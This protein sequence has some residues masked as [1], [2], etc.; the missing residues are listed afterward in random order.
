MDALPE[1][2]LVRAATLEEVI[3]ARARHPDSRLLGGGTDLVVNIRRGIIE[4]PEWE[5]IAE[6]DASVREEAPT[7]RILNFGPL[8]RIPIIK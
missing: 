7:H 1:F 8:S 4:S 6:T 3:G 2:A 5:L